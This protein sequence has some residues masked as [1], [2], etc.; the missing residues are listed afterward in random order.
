[1]FFVGFYS[2]IQDTN[3]AQGPNTVIERHYKQKRFHIEYK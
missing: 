3:M 1:M 2:V